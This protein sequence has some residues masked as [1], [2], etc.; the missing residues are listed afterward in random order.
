MHKLDHF[1]ILLLQAFGFGKSLSREDASF[2]R[3]ASLFLVLI[4]ECIVW[5]YLS[6]SNEI[7]LL[8]NMLSTERANIGVFVLLIFL[9]ALTIRY[10][11][12][13]VFNV[14]PLK[15]TWGIIQE[16]VYLSDRNRFF[17]IMAWLISVSALIALF[18][19]DGL[20]SALGFD[21]LKST[22]TA[23]TILFVVILILN[24]LKDVI[25]NIIEFRA[26]RQDKFPYRVTLL[27]SSE[28]QV[29]L[30]PLN[31]KINDQSHWTKVTNGRLTYH[32]DS[33]NKVLFNS[34]LDPAMGPFVRIEETFFDFP[35]ELEK[36]REIVFRE[37]RRSRALLWN[38]KKVRLASDLDA[39]MIESINKGNQ[40][41]IC[42]QPTTYYDSLCSN[43]I[44][45]YSVFPK[46][47]PTDVKDL[48]KD[49]VKDRS[50][51]DNEPSL[52]HLSTSRLSNHIGINILAIKKTGLL[53]VQKQG[54]AA[55]VNPGRLVPSSSGSL[56]WEDV[57][58]KLKLSRSGSNRIR[59]GDVLLEGMIRELKEE[60]G[61]HESRVF[62]KWVI[63]YSRDLTRGGKP[64]FYGVCIIDDLKPTISGHESQL[65]DLH[66][67]YELNI[68]GSADDFR[69][70]PHLE[71]LVM[72]K[73]T[74][75]QFLTMNIEFLM[76]LPDAAINKILQDIRHCNS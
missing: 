73:G 55:I 19:S 69:K 22:G 68:M 28:L 74:M 61:F 15:N 70:S 24:N 37:K 49:Y 47:D 39:A 66:A 76:A 12:A 75:S 41:M 34:S 40:A 60:D 62:A 25:S 43:E 5:L 54:D 59:L 72:M 64:D 8:A 42:L 46:D 27:P 50:S 32:S 48:W 13:L 3:K 6:N 26:F 1:G 35:D 18:I 67:S 38:E 7:R 23:I 10:L 57:E 56:D 45:L 65:V 14:T 2:R 29:L 58:A 36:Y 71:K 20:V 44:M 52:E 53:V 63:G 4:I 17:R 51:T 31:D 21:K 11:Y 9:V 33:I 30:S 16:L